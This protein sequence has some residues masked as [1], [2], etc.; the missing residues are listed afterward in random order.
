MSVVGGSK[1]LVAGHWVTAKCPLLVLTTDAEQ[2]RCSAP[3]EHCENIFCD[4]LLIIYAHTSFFSFG[5]YLY[6]A[7]NFLIFLSSLVV[8]VHVFSVLQ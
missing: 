2:H 8:F 5:F 6:F 1:I 4:T 7:V 3:R